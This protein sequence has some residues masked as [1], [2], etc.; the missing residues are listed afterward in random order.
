MGLGVPL[1]PNSQDGAGG[2][3]RSPQVWGQ[4]ADGATATSLPCSSMRLLT[5]KGCAAPGL[6]NQLLS[7]S[8]KYLVFLRDD[9]A[10]SFY[11]RLAVA[12]LLLH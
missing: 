4:G 12:R 9:L 1:P 8:K 2:S 5:S 6:S 11:Q 7:K 10:L 3:A